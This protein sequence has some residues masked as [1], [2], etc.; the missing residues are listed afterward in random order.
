MARSGHDVLAFAPDHDDATSAWL[1]ANG[2]T[3]IDFSL[4]REGMTPVKDAT[5]LLVLRRLLRLYKPNITLGYYIN[6]VI[7]G[8]I[9]GWLADRKRA[10]WGQNVTVRVNV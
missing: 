4:A 6:Q 5:S 3:P 7:I 1:R 2:I 8:P 9:A 10:G